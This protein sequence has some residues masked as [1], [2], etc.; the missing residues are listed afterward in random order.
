MSQ[1]ITLSEA[2]SALSAVSGINDDDRIILAGRPTTT[3]SYKN[4][5]AALQQLIQAAITQAAV[6]TPQTTVQGTASQY[7]YSTGTTTDLPHNVFSAVFKCYQ[8]A[9]EARITHKLWGS[10]ADYTDGNY[11]SANLPTVNTGANGVLHRAYFTRLI[12]TTLTESGSSTTAVN[13]TYPDYANGSTK[14]LTLSPATTAKAGIMTTAHV[15]ILNDCNT[16]RLNHNARLTTIEEHYRSL[17]TFESESAA[18]AK[19]ADIP[20][21]SDAELLHAHATYIDG[22]ALSTLTLM[23]NVSGTLCRQIIFNKDKLFHRS[24]TFTDPTRTAIQQKEDWQFLLADRLQ[25]S[26]D[27]H[28]YILSQFGQGFNHSITDP[29]PLATPTVHGLMS[30][31]D[32]TRLDQLVARYLTT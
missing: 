15:N 2:L 24:I 31:Q 12:N 28:K 27:S 25:W 14:T 6:P 23:Q 10:T 32:K 22:D 21:C 1:T 11:I 26:T 30:A 18:L 8:Y 17:G 5:R 16:A 4:L 19:L 3:I 13:I 7:I 20:L 29:I 9:G